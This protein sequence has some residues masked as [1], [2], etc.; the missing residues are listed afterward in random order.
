MCLFVPSVAPALTLSPVATLQ[1]YMRYAL[2]T[3][4][5]EPS[6]GLLVH[7]ISG[8]DRT[9][10]FIGVLR[11]LLWAEG[12]V[13]EHLSAEQM[14]FLVVAYDWMLFGFALPPSSSPRSPPQ[15]PTRLPSRR[16]LRD[17]LLRLL[18]PAA[19]HLARVLPPPC[20]SPSPGLDLHHAP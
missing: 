19:P 10:L 17:L 9:P 11:L 8:W 5:E 15:S 7:C 1:N 16:G 3:L 4:R 13:H 20:P 12:L 6:E 18:G 14:L 2:H